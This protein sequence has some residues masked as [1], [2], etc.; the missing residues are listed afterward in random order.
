MEASRKCSLPTQSDESNLKVLIS[1]MLVVGAGLGSAHTGS[2]INHIASLIFGQDVE[3]LLQ[4]T[5]SKLSVQGELLPA[6]TPA[7]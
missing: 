1:K 3:Q 7:P 6:K 4:T 2:Y 5:A